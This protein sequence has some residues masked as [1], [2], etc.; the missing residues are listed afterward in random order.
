GVNVHYIPLHLQSYYQREFGYK[1]GDYPKAEKYYE[2][3]ITLPLFPMMSDEDA[4]DVI[5]AVKKVVGYHR[6]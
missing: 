5:D 6:R 3:A 1:K 2:R 4:K